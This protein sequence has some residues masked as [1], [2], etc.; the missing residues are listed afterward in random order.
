MRVKGPT[1]SRG[2]KPGTGTKGRGESRK[3]RVP[4]ESVTRRSRTGMPGRQRLPEPTDA[5]R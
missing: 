1:K 4:S 3:E 5:E 2:H